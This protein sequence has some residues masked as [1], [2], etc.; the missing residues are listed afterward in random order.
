MRLSEIVFVLVTAIVLVW[1]AKKDLK[2]RKIP[3]LLLVVLLLVKSGY[4]LALFFL[5]RAVFLKSL[6]DSCLGFFIFAVLCF[7]LYVFLHRNM[8]AGDFKLLIVLAFVVGLFDA[9]LLALILLVL[10]LVCLLWMRIKGTTR[11][12]I[13]M[14]PLATVAFVCLEII[15]LEFIG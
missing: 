3:N 14:A 8:G 7:L 11:T 15:K 9:V 10:A 6:L 13:P 12:R 4:L 2:E 1:I 5:S